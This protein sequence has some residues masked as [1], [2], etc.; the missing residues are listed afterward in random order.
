MSKFDKHFKMETDD[1]LDYIKGKLDFFD[2]DASLKAKEIGDGNINYVFKIWDENTKKSIVIKHADILLRTSG[3]PLD[4]DR[5]RIEA[6]VLSLQ[7]ELAPGLVPKVYKYDPIMCALVMEDISDHGNLREELLEG[8]IFHKLADHITTFMVNTLLPTTDLV[9]D[10]GDKK[11]RVEKFINK[12]LCKISEDLVFTEPYI[13]YKGRNIVLDENMDFVK[14][15]LYGD[16]D[17]ILEVGKLKNNFMNN[18]QA[19]IHGDL[20]SGSIFVT[21]DSMKVIDPEF[22]FY[23][24][25]GYDLGNVI[26][27]LFFPWAKAYVEKDNKDIEEFTNWLGKTIENIVDL[28]KEKF[29]KLYKEIVTDVMAKEEYYMEWY[30]NS[31]LSDAAGSAGLEMIRRVVGDSKV[32]DITNIEN[33]EERVKAERL[34]ILSGKEFIMNREKM[35]IGKDYIDIFKNNM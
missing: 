33:I 27:N 29:I 23:G 30:L 17:L 26:G 34:L 4:V 7:G 10:S 28:F 2:K 9:M 35:K 6:E 32:I 19:L 20:H 1:V 13:D 21:K 14:K 18:T 5:N 15:E 24:P 25:I 11:D 31:I 22:A 3:R 16:K 12:D 8:K